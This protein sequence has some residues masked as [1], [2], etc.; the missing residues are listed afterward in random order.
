MCGDRLLG[1][2]VAYPRSIGAALL[3]PRRLLEPELGS[4]HC[5]PA[6]AFAISLSLYWLAGSLVRRVELGTQGSI[7]FPSLGV[8]VGTVT[9]ILLVLVAIR[10]TFAQV[11]KLPGESPVA[12]LRQLTWTASVGLSAY[13]VIVLWATIFPE[14]TVTLAGSLDSG[15]AMYDDTWTVPMIW[16]HAVDTVSFFPVLGL[17]AWS[18]FNVTRTGFGATPVR[19][20]LATVAAVVIGLVVTSLYLGFSGGISRQV[21]QWTAG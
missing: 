7:D 9:W 3:A 2:L 21:F 13:A 4:N 15:Y 19:A 11:F 12:S 6:V 16:T 17:F 1:W 5:P 20:A 10:A 18:L 14:A 8:V